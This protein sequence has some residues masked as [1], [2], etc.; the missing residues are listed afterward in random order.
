MWHRDGWGTWRWNQGWYHNGSC[1]KTLYPTCLDCHWSC[2]IT[3]LF[4]CLCVCA[5]TYVHSGGYVC[6]CLLCACMHMC[7]FMHVYNIIVNVT[8][9][10]IKNTSWLFSIFHWANLRAYKH[11]Q[12][13]LYRILHIKMRPDFGKLTKLWHL[14]FREIPM[15]KIEAFVV[16]L[17]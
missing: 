5:C 9:F 1:W 11:S 7:V 14:V 10:R 17:C 2:Y 15:L 4:V 3:G 16:F 8:W 6:M 13:S 12:L